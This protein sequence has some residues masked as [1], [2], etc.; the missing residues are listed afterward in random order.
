MNIVTIDI[1]T[2]PGEGYFFGLW[3]QN[4]GLDFLKR[5][6]RMGCFAAKWLGSKEMI[7]RSEFHDG[8]EVMLKTAHEILNDADAVVGYNSR[9]FDVKHLNR[10]LFLEKMSPPSPFAHIDL[11][12]TSKK[13]FAFMSNKLQHLLTE[14]KIGSKIVTEGAPLWTACL[15]GD[16]G[17]WNRMRKYNENDTRETEKLYIEMRPWIKGHP[18]H[19]ALQGDDICTNCGSNDLVKEGIAYTASGSFQRYCCGSCGKWVR[20]NR[21]ISGTSI[22]GIS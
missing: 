20:S 12:E 16:E 2:L 7:F 21:R 14:T 9:K 8:R 18:S 11:M 17:A 13:Q 4:I 22:V 1:E 3:D 6:T 15:D 19:G 5:P 10:E